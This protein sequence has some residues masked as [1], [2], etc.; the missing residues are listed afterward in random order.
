MYETIRARLETIRNLPI[1]EINKRQQRLID[2]L[3]HIVNHETENGQLTSEAGNTA[4]EDMPYWRSL[5]EYLRDAGFVRLGNGHFSA[6]YKH[7]RLPGKVIKVGFKKEDSGAAYVAFCRMHQGLAGIPVIHDVQRHAGCYTVIMDELLTI[8]EAGVAEAEDMHQWATLGVEGVKWDAMTGRMYNAADKAIYETG[9]KIREFF[10]GIAG[11]DMHRGNTMWCPKRETLFITDPVS[12]SLDTDGNRKH[13]QDDWALDLEA[14]EAERAEAARVNL[15]RR[16][17]ARWAANE[18][19]KG[20]VQSRACKAR[21]KLRRKVAEHQAAL[22][23]I[24]R[25]DDRMNI[26]MAKAHAGYTHFS[27]VARVNNWGNI[28]KFLKHNAG[29]F[30]IENAMRIGLQLP[31]ACDLALDKRFM[32]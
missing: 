20:G 6:A 24:E 26:K 17:K 29:R 14:I 19:R 2:L 22:Q 12:F 3:V 1:C 9:Q 13:G 21:R 25:H 23:V 27:R 28:E 4:L 10:K 8:D 18:R 5:G 16:C 31:L 7:A 30:R 32:G 15:V 11:F